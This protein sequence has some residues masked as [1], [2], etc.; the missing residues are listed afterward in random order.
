MNKKLL[1][2]AEHKKK[3]GLS[4]NQRGYPLYTRL[5]MGRYV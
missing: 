2:V 5:Y 1:F 4:T 3:A